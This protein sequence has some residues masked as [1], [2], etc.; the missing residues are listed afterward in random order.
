MQDNKLMI[1]IIDENG[2]KQFNVPKLIKKVALFSGLGII[3]IV[4]LYL[5]MAR[6]LFAELEVILANNMQ[7]R[8]NFQTIYEKNNELKRNIDY[9]TSELLKVTS[10][11]N[12]LE[13]IINTNSNAGVVIDNSNINLDELSHAQKDII[14]KLV[15]NG[16]PV[17]NFKDISCI[18]K[19]SCSYKIASLTPVYATAN[20]I[21]DSIRMASSSSNFIQIQHSYGFVSNYGHL[22]R[23]VVKKGDFVTKGQVIGYSGGSGEESSLY[24]DLRFLDSTLDVANYTKWNND[25]FNKVISTSS[26]VDWQNLVW[27]L[28]DIA[29]LKNYRVSQK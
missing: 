6:F 16:N 18:N 10:K 19:N 4:I 28:D 14:L 24:Y 21:V 22:S 11:A 15:P 29:Q 23:L 3:C 9:K 25:D 2:S 1:S 13:T 12:E 17:N 27:V 5:V 8:E 20:G 26:V 7:T